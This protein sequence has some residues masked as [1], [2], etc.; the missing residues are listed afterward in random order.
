[1]STE[2]L[3]GF[4]ALAE[5][6]R[7]FVLDLW[8]VIHDGVTPYPGA[9]DALR[10]LRAAGKR[11]VLLSNA[12]RRSHVA[13]SALAALGVG[14]DLYDAVITSGEAAW[15]ALGAWPGARVRHLGAARDLS[16]VEGRDLTLMPSPD[17]ADLLLNTGPDTSAHPDARVEDFADEL[18]RCLRAGLPMWC[19]NPDLEIV[20]AGRRLI[21]AGALAEWYAAEGGTVRWIGKPFAEVYDLVWPAL[22][23]MPRAAVLA[24]GDSLRTD[25]AGAAGVGLESCWILGGIHAHTDPALAEREAAAAGLM[26]RATLLAFAW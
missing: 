1:M 21:C 13:A 12:P 16:V 20:S 17:G 9:V 14:P 3:S 7:G 11:V 15:I 4:A 19:A 25:I 10:R 18:R 24:V 2:H 8:G 23:D 22:G 26:P 6:Y 5:R